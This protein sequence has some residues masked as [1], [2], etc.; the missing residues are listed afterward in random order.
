MGEVREIKVPLM[1]C[2]AGMGWDGFLI[3]LVGVGGFDEVMMR[4]DCVKRAF[5]LT[6]DDNVVAG[7][8]VVR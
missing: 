2:V 5:F 1:L 8:W 4:L 6:D 7:G 3:G